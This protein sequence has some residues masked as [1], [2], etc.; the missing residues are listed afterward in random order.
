MMM[1]MIMMMMM[2]MNDDVLNHPNPDDCGLLPDMQDEPN[3]LKKNTP[4]KLIIIS[5]IYNIYIYINKKIIEMLEIKHVFY[6][7]IQI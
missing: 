2:M 4:L 3:T 1:V 6:T 5:S 7:W